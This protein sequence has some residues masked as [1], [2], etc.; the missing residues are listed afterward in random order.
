M[1]LL[2]I[3]FTYHFSAYGSR[4]KQQIGEEEFFKLRT[5]SLPCKGN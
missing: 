1:Y 4:M 2:D 5:T 3:A